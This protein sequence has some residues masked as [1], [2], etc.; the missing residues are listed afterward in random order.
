MPEVIALANGR[1]GTWFLEAS[2][3]SVFFLPEPESPGSN[4]VFK[5]QKCSTLCEVPMSDFQVGF[6]VDFS[7]LSLFLFLPSFLV[8]EQ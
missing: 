3:T 1:D 7:S 2:K 6:A 5:R 4:P 8:I